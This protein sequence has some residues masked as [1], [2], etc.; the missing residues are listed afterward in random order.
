MSVDSLSF[1]LDELTD[2]DARA[3]AYTNAHTHTHALT[4]RLF[5]LETRGIHM[6]ACILVYLSVFSMRCSTHITASTIVNI[7]LT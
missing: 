4:R 1:R 2:T 7:L 6:Q 5:I 3:L